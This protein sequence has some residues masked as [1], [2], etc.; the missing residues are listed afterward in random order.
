MSPRGASNIH[1]ILKVSKSF[2]FLVIVSRIEFSII[3]LEQLSQCARMVTHF[4]YVGVC[5]S[6]SNCY[7][8][9]VLD[10]GIFWRVIPVFFPKKH[11]FSYLC[12]TWHCFSFSNIWNISLFSKT[13]FKRNYPQTYLFFSLSY[14]PLLAFKYLIFYVISSSLASTF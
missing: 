10:S 14:L 5:I 9:H 3:S 7:F 12:C 6:T 4:F 2:F 1:G 11:C 8:H 13:R